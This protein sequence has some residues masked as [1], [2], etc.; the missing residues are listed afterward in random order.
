MQDILVKHGFTG[1]LPQSN[2]GYMV[3][4]ATAKKVGLAMLRFYMERDKAD[5][6]CKLPQLDRHESACLAYAL[7][8]TMTEGKAKHF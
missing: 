6:D 3:S 5:P 4:K 2:D 1:K 8:L 7:L